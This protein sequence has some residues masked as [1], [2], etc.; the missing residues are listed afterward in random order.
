MT[1]GHRTHPINNPKAMPPA[2]PENH[3]HKK[4]FV[5]SLMAQLHHIL[6]AFQAFKR[7]SNGAGFTGIATGRG[8]TGLSTRG[9]VSLTLTDLAGLAAAR[10]LALFLAGFFFAGFFAMLHS[11]KVRS[12]AGP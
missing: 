11:Q 6:N 2:N 7:M 5:Y 1:V 3:R 12:C 4:T 9:F 10:F 8:S